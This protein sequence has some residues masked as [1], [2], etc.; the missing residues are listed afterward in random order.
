MLT[1]FDNLNTEKIKICKINIGTNV[2]ITWQYLHLYCKSI[3][4]FMM[5]PFLDFVS[6]EHQNGDYD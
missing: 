3:G 5:E 4:R 2:F 6:T 1:E